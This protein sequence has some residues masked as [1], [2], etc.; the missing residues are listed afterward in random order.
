MKND[1]K[2]AAR[3]MRA[4]GYTLQKISNELGVSTSSVSKWTRDIQLSEEESIRLGLKNFKAR[5]N[6]LKKIEKHN[7]IRAKW[8]EEGAKKAQLNND[9]LH[10]AGCMLYWA[11]GHKR[12]NK[13]AV[14]F[15]N[16]D[17]AMIKL[18]VKF[19]RVCFN[20]E[21]EEISIRCSA[22]LDNDLCQD[23]IENYW[24]NITE[25]DVSNLTSFIEGN[26]ANKNSKGKRKKFRSYGMC[27]IRVHDT[28]I[29]QQIYGSI[30]EYGS[31][32]TD[33]F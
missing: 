18:F 32:E 31:L 15:V 11:E 10:L 3:N 20:V 25:L 28:K 26:Y 21:D 30:K 14:D 7:K 5:E 2:V 27:C 1:Q 17:P 12:N 23:D 6:G 4:K 8:Q 9:S 13:N 24:L 33:E 22:Y 19:L 16:S 29:I